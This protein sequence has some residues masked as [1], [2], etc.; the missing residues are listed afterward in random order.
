VTVFRHGEGEV[1]DDAP[2]EGVIEGDD[3]AALSYDRSNR[4]GTSDPGFT[5]SLVPFKEGLK[6]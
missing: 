3:R 1:F 2:L 4:I 6:A 5:R